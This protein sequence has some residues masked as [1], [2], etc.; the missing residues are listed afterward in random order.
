MNSVT[1]I[2][3]RIGSY[4]LVAAMSVVLFAVFTQGDQPV[5]TQQTQQPEETQSQVQESRSRFPKLEELAKLIDE[6]YIDQ[7]DY[8]AMEDAAAAA[9]IDALPDAW[10]YYVSASE[11]DSFAED[12][13]NAYVGIGIT[14]TAREDDLGFDIIIV[15]PDSPAQKAGILPGDILA[16]AEGK[17]VAEMGMDKT[18]DTVRGEEGT[19]VNLEILRGEELIPMTVTRM[20]ITIQVVSGEMLEGNIG[21]VYI[22]NFHETCC[23]Q[24][25][26]AIEQLI[27]QG[28]TSLILDVRDNGGG[29]KT[30]LV[31]LLDYLLPEGPLFRSVDYNNNEVIDYS[32]EGCLE[33][34]M[35]VMVNE[36]SY[37]AAEFFA[38]ALS[39]YE[40]ATVVG[41]QTT[42]KSYFQNTYILDDGSAVVMSTGK[43]YT[44]NGV[45]LAEVGGLV[46]DVVVEVDDETAAMIYA[47]LLEP[48]ED[49]QL[50]AAMELLK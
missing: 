25:V 30:Q 9:F 10:S 22:A 39:E 7:E 18:R 50:V 49:P 21:Y 40:W 20:P 4:V 34:P 1:K 42:G 15:E 32:K 23:D 45:S 37:S 43:Y 31:E 24:T 14:I 26:K 46:P 8:Q 44:P 5:A 36:Y 28:A 12:R 11:F 48:H 16:T 38:A 41:A 3:L 17:S 19:E 47:G 27:E 6:K 33:M 35:V 29:Y 2:L 13:A